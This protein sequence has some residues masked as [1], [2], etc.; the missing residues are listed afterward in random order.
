MTEP[1]QLA[2]AERLLA[3]DAFGTKCV[4]RPIMD[5]V[6]TRWA[7]LILAALL[8]G[9]HRFSELH[10]RVGGISQKMLSQNL[11]ALAR[12]GLVAREV[13]PT[14]PPQVTYSLTPLGTDLA[15]RLTELIS[16]FGRNGEELLRAQS[17]YDAAMS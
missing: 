11:K 7:T 4:F 2:A 5:Q 12:N 10:Q 9:P 16:W 3:V 14:I 6:T 17:D 8:I 13:E 15:G 1:H